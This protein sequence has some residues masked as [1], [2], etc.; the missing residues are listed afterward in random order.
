MK[1]NYKSTVNA[2]FAGYVVQAIVNNFVPL[3]FLTFN[4]SYGIELS[5]ITALI[6]VNFILQLIID[7]L[8]AFF[9]DKIGYRAAAIMAHVFAA[10]GLVSLTVLPEVLPS[11]FVGLLVSVVLYAV[12]GGLLEVIVSPIVEACPTD[13]KEKMMSLLHSFYCWGSVAVV[14]ISTLYFSIFTTA[15]WKYLALIWAVVPAVNALNFVRVPI[16]PLIEEGETG[17]SFK[18]LLGNRMFWIFML[19]ILCSG[20]SEQAVSL[21]G[22]GSR[23]LKDSRRP[24][25]P[26]ALLRAH[27]R[28]ARD[29]RQIRRQNRPRRH[30]DF[31]RRAVHGV[32]SAHC[33]QLLRCAR[34]CR[35]RDVRLLG[36]HHVAGNVQQGVRGDKGRRNG[37]VRSSGA[38]RRSRLLFRTHFC[39]NDG[40]RIRRRSQKRHT[41]RHIFPGAFNRADNFYKTQKSENLISKSGRIRMINPCSAA[42]ICFC[43]LHLQ[44]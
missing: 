17:L 44:E 18:Q 33:A 42:L 22:K 31:Q 20:A 39:R 13:N 29:I 32:L 2:C 40:E 37:D 43:G 41:L 14:G 25:R 19:L 27:G 4:K 15:N 7:L 3:L 8:S 26:H 28:V 16:A 12:G 11:P 10:A 38:R 21:C 30:D 5:K 23:R 24:R 35:S 36:R 34:A 6:T 9:I 1:K